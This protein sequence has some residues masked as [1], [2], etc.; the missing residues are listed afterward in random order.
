MK[1]QKQRLEIIILTQITVSDGKE[2]M[3]LSIKFNYLVSQILYW[4]TSFNV[5]F[6][7][8]SYRRQDFSCFR[9]SI[10]FQF[11]IS[12]FWM[13]FFFKNDL[14]SSLRFIQFY[15]FF[16]LLSILSTNSPTGIWESLS[17]HNP[18]PCNADS[19][20]LQWLQR[21]QNSNKWSAQHEK[22]K[23]A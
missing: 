8:R 2:N 15:V 12:L 13:Y 23:K 1:Q 5:T 16:S 19:Q 14:F 3:T 21:E 11:S 20:L 7:W 22:K 9:W 18:P 6:D 10:P 17:N 4:R